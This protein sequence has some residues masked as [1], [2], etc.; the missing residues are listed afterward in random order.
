MFGDQTALRGIRIDELDVMSIIITKPAY[1]HE[2]WEDM[3]TSSP[4]I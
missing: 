2:T 1:Y 4:M 3:S